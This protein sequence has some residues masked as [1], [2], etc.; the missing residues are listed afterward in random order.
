MKNKEKDF[1]KLSEKWFDNQARVY[2]KTGT[3]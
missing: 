3:E 1:V 2:D